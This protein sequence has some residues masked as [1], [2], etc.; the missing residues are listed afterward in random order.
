[1]VYKQIEKWK[2]YRKNIKLKKKLN[3]NNIFEK[4]QLNVNTQTIINCF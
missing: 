3:E 4:T 2:N 1:M